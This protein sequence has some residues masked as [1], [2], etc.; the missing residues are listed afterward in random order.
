MSLQNLVN[1]AYQTLLDNLDTSR[2][3]LL[4]PQS[5]YRSMVIAKLLNASGIKVLYYAM[6]PDDVNLQSL[7]SSLTHDLADQ[8]PVFGRHINLLPKDIYEQPETHL[9]LVVETFSQDLAEISEE[10]FVLI[11]DEYDRSD[12][13]ESVQRFVERLSDNLPP[14]CRIVINSRTSPRLPWVAMVAGNRAMIIKDSHVILEDFSDLGQHDHLNLEIYGFGPGFVLLEGEPIDSWEGHL[15][16]LLFFFVLDRRFVTRSEI[17][18]AF[19]PELDIDQAVNVFHVTKRR[20][21]VALDYD[22]LVHNDNY[23][24]INNEMTI[25]YD[26][27]EFASE[28]MKTRISNNDKENKRSWK[29]AIELY[30]DDFLQSHED[31]WIIERRKAFRNGYVEALTN[32]ARLTIQEG[33]A[34]QGLSLLQK[35]L[36]QHPARED[37]HRDLMQTY[38]DLGRRGDIEKQFKTLAKKLK[39]EG[40]TPE[41]ATQ[42]LYQSLME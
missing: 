41:E 17:C 34:P 14:A 13:S 6:G 25:Y 15:P 20:L 42:A 40:K 30:R 21:H 18:G 37:I 7:I 1:E 32:L 31:P 16:R 36:D 10:P 38:A 11:L 2:V 29:R 23:Y 35:A 24:S 3:I 5:K 26:A 27:N 4:H 19:W 39:T 9:A 8:H 12:R 22:A 33:N 28:L